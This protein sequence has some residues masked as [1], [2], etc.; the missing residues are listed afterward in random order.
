[1]KPIIIAA[2]LMF[3]SFMLSAQQKGYYRTPCIYQNIVV[4]TAEGDLWKYDMTNGIT[5]RLTTDQGMETNPSISQ[6]GKYIVF[7]GQYEG[8]TELYEMDINGSVPKRLTYNL[9]RTIQASGWTSDGKII[10][11]TMAY[12]HLPSLQLFKLDPITFILE[13]IPLWEASFGCY[14]KQGVLFF[15]RLP[16]QGSKTKRY[17]GGFIEQIWSFDGKQE[18]KCLTSDFEGTSTRPMIYNDRVYFLTDRDGTM[19]IWSMDKNGKD[20]K[21]H[22][23]SK[24]WDIQTQSIYDSNIVYQKGADIFLYNI[25]TNTEKRLDI[26]LPSDFDQRKPKWF[27]NPVTS[28]T[29][30]EISPK[31]N[32]AAIISRGRLFVSPSKSDRWVEVTRK[33]GIRFR[34]VHF[35]DER[36]LAALSDQSGEFEIWEMSADGSDS[37]KQIT[38]GSK[39]LITS[40]AISSD[41]K[42]VAYN[43]KNEVLRIAMIST[44]QVKF[45]YTDSHGGTS[46]IG[47]SHDSRFMNFVRILDNRNKQICVVDIQS[48]KMIPVTTTRLN[49]S[50]PSWSKDGNWLYFTSE[51]NLHTK[52][53]SPWGPRQPEPYYTE[54]QNIYAIPLSSKVKCP[55]IQNDSWL[56]D[57]TFKP[58]QVK[59]SSIINDNMKLTDNTTVTNRSYDWLKAAR[60]LYQ[61]PVKSADLKK[62]VVADGFL[63]WLDTTNFNGKNAARLYALKVEENKKHEPTE[64]AS[65]VDDFGLSADSRK[66]LIKYTNKTIAIADANGQKIDSEKTKLELS[67]WNFVVDPVQD[68]KQMYVDAWRMMRDYFYDRDLHKV[69]WIEVRKR[70]ESLLERVTDR[71]ELDDL[72]SQ[73]VGELSA[74]HTFVGGGDKRMSSDQIQIGFLVAFL[75]KTP[76]GLT[77]EHI[78]KSD[79][80]YPNESSPLDKP[81][82]IIQDGDIITEVNNVS[83]GDVQDIAELLA[84]KVGI[85]V[86]LSLL[87]K[88]MKPFDQV[89][90][91]ISATDDYYLRFNEWEFKCR[92]KVDSLSNNDIGYIHLKAMAGASSMDEF[93][94]QFYPVF[95]R[96]GLIIDVRHNTGGSIDSWILEKLMRK[97]WMYWQERSGGPTWNMQYAFRGLM[98]VLCDQMTESDGEAFTEGFRRLGLGKVIGMR[99]WGGEIWLRR[100]N[101]LVDNGIATAAEIGVYGPEGSWLIEGHG[102]EPDIIVDNLPFETYKGKDAQLDFAVDYLMKEIKANP[103]DVPGAPPHP[104]KSIKY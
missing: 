80:D 67:N 19:N 12:S 59:D 104:D 46:E 101:V 25:K 64:I 61:V 62:M 87:R 82:L 28:I 76:S 89:I 98:V 77:I 32:Y 45:E 54:T 79:P 31:G 17:K 1:M 38:K 86:K 85:P 3:T 29:Y 91:P 58:S 72:I 14:D 40:F 94:K 26:F 97:A 44:G 90:K 95:T 74:L 7:S 9:D 100:D 6:D 8:Y 42:Y 33:S 51:R 11:R 83:I 69:D 99:T 47:W 55:F 71:D 65:G 53:I 57:S 92:G 41:R 81:E 96:K 5:S 30:T 34:E 20:L 35:I 24:N 21:Q 50:S 75:K 56:M 103:L 36:N 102:V 4:F 37:A 43:D 22:T 93:V 88:N 18:A 13:P 52:V 84:N 60:T 63:Y 2:F 49:N 78:Y 48:M 23:F 39:T 66:L 16:K 27:K 68:W 15:S 73:M 70:Y 10:Y